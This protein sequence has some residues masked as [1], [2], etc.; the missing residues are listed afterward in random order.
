[1][2][3]QPFDD[4]SVTSRCDEEEGMQGLN[5]EL[6]RF[7]ITGMDTLPR[8]ESDD[9]WEV[10]SYA[11][12][13]M[14]LAKLR[15]AHLT[16]SHDDL[17]YGDYDDDYSCSDSS[18]GQGSAPAPRRGRSQYVIPDEDDWTVQSD[19]NDSI[20]L[21]R[22]HL[23]MKVGQKVGM[24]P[25]PRVTRR[26]ASM[27]N[28][29]GQQQEQQQQQSPRRVVSSR[30][31]SMRRM[32]MSSVSTV[33]ESVSGSSQGSGNS[34]DPAGRRSTIVRHKSMPYVKSTT[35]GSAMPLWPAGSET[36]RQKMKRRVS[37]GGTP[38]AA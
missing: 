4:V 13:S 22:E 9:S 12:D 28:Y 5:E 27:D 11:A 38:C 26:R 10:E 3:T 23:G 24:Q 25:L 35:G 8:G 29:M 33:E 34:N 18:R 36:P 30:P 19:C 7:Q 20:G 6:N 2:E 32:S 37:N 14:N 31:T 17:G 15:L 16:L 21:T 1:M